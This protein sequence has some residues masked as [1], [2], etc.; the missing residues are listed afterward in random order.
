MHGRIQTIYTAELQHRM[1]M[2]GQVHSTE[3]GTIG[4]I[5]ET[6][7]CR[8][9]VFGLSPVTDGKIRSV[10]FYVSHN[11]LSSFLFV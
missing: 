6:E 2:L 8:E 5:T 1:G 3:S 7:C 4:I 10:N 9:R 11:T